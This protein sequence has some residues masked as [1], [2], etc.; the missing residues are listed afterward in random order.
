MYRKGIIPNIPEG[1]SKKQ[2][3]NEIRKWARIEE[4]QGP[5]ALRHKGIKKF[6]LQKKN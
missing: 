4:V 2:F 5:D 1:L 3:R 6:G